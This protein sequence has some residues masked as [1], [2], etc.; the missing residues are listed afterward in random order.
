MPITK[1]GQRLL[2]KYFYLAAETARQ[3]DREFAAYYDAGMR[4]VTSTTAS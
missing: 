3:W 1:A 2:K 4:A